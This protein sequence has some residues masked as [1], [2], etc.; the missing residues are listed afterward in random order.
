MKINILIIS[1]FLLAGTSCISRKYKVKS[2]AKVSEIE[3]SIHSQFY[4]ALQNLNLK[5]GITIVPQNLSVKFDHAIT[6]TGSVGF[7]A[8]SIVTANYQYQNIKDNSVTDILAPTKI[9]SSSGGGK[10]FK[11]YCPFTPEKS[12][13][14]PKVSASIQNLKDIIEQAA[15]AFS[16]VPS[17]GLLNDHQV[18]VDIKFTFS[19]DGNISI[20]PTFT[21]LILSKLTGK[22]DKNVASTDDIAFTFDVI[23]NDQSTMSNAEYNHL[24]DSIIN[25]KG[26]ICSFFKNADYRDPNSSKFL[27]TPPVQNQHD[28]NSCV[29]YA[30]GYTCLSTILNTTHKQFDENNEYSPDFIFARLTDKKCNGLDLPNVL[31][32]VVKEGDCTIKELPIVEKLDCATYKSPESKDKI[33]AVLSSSRTI[34]SKIVNGWMPLDPNDISQIRSCLD[35]DEPVIAAFY[36]SSSFTNMWDYGDPSFPNKNIWRSQNGPYTDAHCVCIIGYD[37]KSKMFKV[38]NSWGKTNS[39]AKNNPEEGGYFWVTYD[40]VERG[41][42]N[43]AYTFIPNI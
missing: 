6:T 24:R 26:G 37:N 1:F 8:F 42:F 30:V 19:N 4:A 5:K 34:C 40:L 39:A 11:I 7:T 35:N 25:S 13:D 22:I 41:C 3:K 20:S 17:M 15:E 29:A 14:D 18:T 12:S 38:Q 43:Q 33:S 2:H 28:F 23:Q 16:D 36:E 21:Y 32:Q 10:E 9:S 31:N 27:T